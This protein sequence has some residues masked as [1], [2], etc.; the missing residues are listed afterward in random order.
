MPRTSHAAQPSLLPA[1]TRK[2]NRNFKPA[3]VING[4]TRTAQNAA[5][6]WRSDPA[7]PLPQ[8][9]ELDFGKPTAFNTVQLTFVTNPNGHRP[10]LPFSPA[11]VKNY[12]VEAFVAGKWV[13]VVRVRDNFQRHRVHSFV[14]QT[15]TK[16]RVTVS[17]THGAKSA[18]VFEVRVYEGESK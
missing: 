3:N 16:L 18:S 13:R 12:D 6:M 11:C 5:S 2:A 1:M 9:V 4:W 17:A 8:W 7:Q 14:T 15:A 10:K